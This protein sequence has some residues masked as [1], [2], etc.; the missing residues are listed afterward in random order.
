[1]FEVIFAVTRWTG[2][3]S[4]DTSYVLTVTD[5]IALYIQFFMHFYLQRDELK[6]SLQQVTLE[7]EHANQ[8]ISELSSLRLQLQA[9]K[10]E[11]LTMQSKLTEEHVHRYVIY[12]TRETITNISLHFTKELQ[13]LP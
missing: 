10:E 9:K 2:I 1:M 13:I 8:T 5:Q 6:A 3:I 12:V 4:K 11:I 7:L